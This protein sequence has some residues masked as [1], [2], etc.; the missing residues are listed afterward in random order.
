MDGQMQSDAY[1]PTMHK[2]RCAKTRNLLINY[3]AYGIYKF[4]VQSENNI[5][6]FEQANVIDVIKKD[7]ISRTLYITCK[8]KVFVNIADQII[9]NL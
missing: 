7:M 2:H 6:N 3:T 9:S 8:D 5:V 4:W 1:Q